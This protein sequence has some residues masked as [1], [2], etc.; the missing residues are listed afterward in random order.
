LAE[1]LSGRILQRLGV[2]DKQWCSHIAPGR[3]RCTGEILL[4]RAVIVTVCRLKN[5]WSVILWHINLLDAGVHIWTQNK[6]APE[7]L[8]MALS[9]VRII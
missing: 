4:G 6:H 3:A 1:L 7:V 8:L 5:E 2:Q 9:L